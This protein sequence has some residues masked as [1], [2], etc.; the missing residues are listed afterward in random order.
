MRRLRRD[1]DSEHAC[2]DFKP[3]RCAGKRWLQW[4]TVLL[5]CCSSYNHA[6]TTSF[7]LEL[8]INGRNSGIIAEAVH[9]KDSWLLKAQDLIAAGIRA[10]MINDELLLLSPQSIH[11]WEYD[12]DN[13]RMSIILPTRY[14][15]SQQL[16]HGMEKNQYALAQRDTS[17]LINY[18]LYAIGGDGSLSQQSLAHSI[19]YA[20]PTINFVSNGLYTTGDNLE[21]NGYLR[22]DTRLQYDNPEKL[23]SLAA[24]DIITGAPAWGRNYRMGGIRFARDYSLNPDLIR[25]PV[26][27]FLGQAALPG[28]V[29]LL[30]NEQQRFSSEVNPGPF[31]ISSP[32]W[33]TG[34]GSASIITTDLQGRQ[35]QQNIS[36]YIVNELLKPGYSDYDISVGKLRKDFGIQSDNYH[37]ALLFSGL[38]RYGVTDYLTP[39][40]FAQSSRHLNMGGI[41]VT[42]RLGH[43]GSAEASYA[44]SR[45]RALQGSQYTLGYRY[46]NHRYGLN[47]RH[48]RRSE[49]F[50]D[51]GAID[52]FQ[53][54]QQ[55]TQA[56]VS[57]TS[58]IGTFGASYFELLQRD[59]GNPRFFNV[60]WSKHFFE[61]ITAMLSV[62][63][64]LD[65]DGEA[66][67]HFGLSFPLGGK[68]YAST[69]TQ[70]DA[71][72]K[73]SNFIQAMQQTP[74]AGGWGWRVAADDHSYLHAFVD[75][76]SDR[77]TAQT[78]VWGNNQQRSWSADIS[79]SLVY[80]KQQW[81]MAREI[82]DAYALVDT[83]GAGR[84]PVYIGYQPIGK[85]NK[86]GYFLIS[87]L[88]GYAR[89][90]IAINP[91]DLPATAFIP[92]T[93]QEV[94]PARQAG[95]IVR[96]PIEQRFAIF[97]KLKNS[98]GDYL[99]AGTYL[100]DR[101]TLEEVIVGWDGDIFL[102]SPKKRQWE[103][104][105]EDENC[106]FTIPIPE[107][108]NLAFSGAHTCNNNA[109]GVT[110]S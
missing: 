68:V 37:D 58:N 50:R 64:R 91:L 85:T 84:V 13:Q 96:F 66:T 77:L 71:Q 60:S 31:V 88:V 65:D 78:G 33:V 105:A 32:S 108:D 97:A 29:E 70:R 93:E 90:R 44:Q 21:R 102:E 8:I 20:T 40:I 10:D 81:F 54:P 52:N 67:L 98:N 76:R 36:F 89:N 92:M 82:T 27:E 72:G 55:E 34:A 87:D 94:I 104:V 19:N 14:F 15:P 62:S 74:F 75:W 2:V 56:G 30:V 11:E 1:I 24:G 100:R 103:L 42:T 110:S 26:P 28:S 79:G 23:W 51:A 9:E 61:S 106:V 63:R 57:L 107:D 41:G 73:S 16:L 48:I 80:M 12:Q 95:I 109:S 25:F 39:E 3:T 53:M 5:L 49:N 43:W 18:S 7:F 47:L 35:S 17:L 4:S 101:N 59:M 46:H 22:L 99:P 69:S 83:N 86:R 6:E 45:Y 38:Y